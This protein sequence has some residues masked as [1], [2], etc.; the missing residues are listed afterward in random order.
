MGLR[1]VAATDLAKIVEN[2]DTGF[3]WDI[4]LT[5]PAGTS[6]PLKGVSDDISQAID[7]DTGVMVSGRFA[8]VGLVMQTIYDAGFVLP[9]GISDSSQRPWLVAFSDI[10]GFPYTF[11]VSE[12]NPDRMLGLITCLLEAYE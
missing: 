9:V 6:I 12:S 10:N 1:E 11:K 8:S 5:N 7:P 3:G 2:I 4:T